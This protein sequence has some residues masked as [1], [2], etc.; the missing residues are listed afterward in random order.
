MW[1]VWGIGSG[2]HKEMNTDPTI[3][4]TF[5]QFPD[6][7]DSVGGFVKTVLSITGIHLL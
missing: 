6:K 3:T 5:A 7:S 2:C 4:G 1:L